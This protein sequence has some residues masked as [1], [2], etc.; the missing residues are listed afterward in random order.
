[1]S[2]IDVESNDVVAEIALAG[3]ESLVSQTVHGVAATSGGVW[4]AVSGGDLVR[5]DRDENRPVG[6]IRTGSDQLAVAA[7]QGALWVLRP[8]QLLRIQ[9]ATLAV[10]ARLPVG[11]GFAHDVVTGDDGVHVLSDDIWI[12]DPRSATLRQTLGV[13]GY[14][15]AVADPPGPGLWAATYDGMLVHFADTESAEPPVRVRVGERPSGIV[16]DEGAVWVAIGD[17]EY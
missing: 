4:A 16:V 15:T 14:V 12:V 9:P 7:G 17:A 13:G 8:G 5:I 3:P 6:S 11:S 1:V 10:S 2:R